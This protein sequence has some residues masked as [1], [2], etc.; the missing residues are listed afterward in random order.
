MKFWCVNT[1]FFGSGRI[2]IRTYQVEADQKPENCMSENKM[3]DEYF[4]YFDIYEEARAFAKQAEE[5]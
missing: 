1:K 3:C 5:A 2:T 4:N